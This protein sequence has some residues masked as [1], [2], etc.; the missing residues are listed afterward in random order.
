MDK[1][2]LDVKGK[3]I[4][5]YGSKTIIEKEQP[6]I[7][8]LELTGNE[9]N[10]R[11]LLQKCIDENKL[12]SDILYDGN[13]V[14]PFEKIVKAYRKLQKSGSLENLTNEMY[15]FFMYACGDIAHYDLGGFKAYYNYSFLELENTLLKDNWLMNTRYSDLDNIFKELKIGKYFEERD[16]INIDNVSL[17][18]LKSIIKNCGWNI[19]Q[20][21]NSWELEKDIIHSQKYSFKVDVSSKSVSNIVSQIMD[22]CYNF[23]KNEYM[24]YLIKNR[25]ESENKLNVADVVTV[26]NNI[27]SSLSKLADKVLYDCRLEAQENKKNITQNINLQ[28][29]DY[30]YDMCG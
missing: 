19:T 25:D 16:Y 24:E 13:T 21:N 29:D 18:K 6:I 27:D 10:D 30:D 8:N 28:Q 22:L 17:N 14:Y 9:S 11:L 3:K 23:N 26:A 4:T 1:K 15:H 20:E 5:L 7:E 12:K 2:E